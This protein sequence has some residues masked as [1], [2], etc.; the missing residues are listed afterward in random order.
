MRQRPGTDFETAT[1]GR[2]AGTIGHFVF[3]Q[4]DPAVGA[5]KIACLGILAIL[6]W[7]GVL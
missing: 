7:G 2:P 6:A 1:T 4:S 5:I 3:G